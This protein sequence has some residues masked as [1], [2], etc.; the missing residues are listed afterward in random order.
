MSWDEHTPTMATF[1]MWFEKPS[2]WLLAYC[3]VMV[4][5]D[6]RIE[7]TVLAIRFKYSSVENSVGASIGPSD[8][9]PGIVYN[10]V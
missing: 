4:S 7:S 9:S 6:C 1:L 5:S 2:G 8:D 10:I 3:W